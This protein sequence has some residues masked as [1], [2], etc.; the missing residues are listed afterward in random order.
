[1]IMEIS[2]KRDGNQSFMIIKNLKLDEED[3][4]LQMVLNNNIEGILSMDTRMVNNSYE[5]YY[6]TTSMISMK[7]MYTR[8]KISGKEIYKLI[9]EIK[10]LSENMKEYLLDINNILFDMEYIYINSQ[11]KQYK[12]CYCPGKVL[13]FQE[14]IKKLMEQLLEYIDYDDKEAVLIAYGM[15]QVVMNEDF[16]IQDLIECAKTN[17]REKDI[18]NEKSDVNP[19][20]VEEISKEDTENDFVKAVPE[21]NNLLKIIKS[22]L[23]RKNKYMDEEQLARKRE[24]MDSYK[25]SFANYMV[26]QDEE[27]ETTFLGL[28]Q[29]I[30]ELTLR[31]IH[32]EEPLK[33]APDS[34]PYI[35]G[36][37]KRNSDFYIKNPAISR[38]HM[39]IVENSSGYFIEDL[40]ST[41]GTF[42]N[43]IRLS[44]H[45]L[46]L[47]KVGD[48]VTLANIDFIVE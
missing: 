47:I 29:G 2:Y 35:V 39:R 10:L 46:K 14:E 30:S 17:I 48:Q 42:V 27:H 44:P 37:S 25:E 26:I 4:R 32:M 40:S 20:I 5:I 3:Y 21:K 31:S 7:N 41:N 6:C 15:Q 18:R 36:K 45:E 34:F 22:M 13:G 28:G 12:F 1:M 11:R 23:G 24:G 43:G 9:K 8:N 19:I 16:T 33:I 38:M